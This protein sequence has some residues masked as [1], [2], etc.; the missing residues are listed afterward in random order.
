MGSLRAE[1]WPGARREPHGAGANL[2]RS[3]HD[4]AGAV[5]GNADRQRLID[6]F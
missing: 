4:R 3:L 1:G 2:P 6:N 5:G